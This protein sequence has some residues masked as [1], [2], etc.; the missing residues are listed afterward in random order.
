MTP[1]QFQ[2]ALK[3][4]RLSLTDAARVLGMSRRNVAYLKSGEVTITPSRADSIRVRL[5]KYDAEGT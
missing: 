4:R 1:K 5:D 3:R 2:R